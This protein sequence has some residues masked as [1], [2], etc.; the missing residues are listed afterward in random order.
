MIS[1]SRQLTD[2][3]HAD[4]LNA[5]PHLHDRLLL[6]ELLDAHGIEP[7]A[8]N[9]E[10]GAADRP[11]RDAALRAD[12]GPPG[13]ALRR[14]VESGLRMEALLGR[15]VG[16]VLG[17]YHEIDRILVWCAGDARLART[18]VH[19]VAPSQVWVADSD[20]DACAWQATHLGVNALFAVADP[21][22]FAL[23]LDFSLVCAGSI[24]AGGA[25]AGFVR[26]IARLNRCVAKR[27]VLVFDAGAEGP[28]REPLV[29]QCV[30]DLFPWRPPDVVRLPGAQPGEPELF[31]V[32]GRGTSLRGLRVGVASPDE[33]D[34]MHVDARTG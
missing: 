15:I 8:F 2:S 33:F 29:R 23:P 13:R 30:A 7:G 11:F 10:L 32:A 1:P 12:G 31:V 24:P 27:G 26:W 34:A 22:R 19:R 5:V 28:R 18:L 17:G 9:T 4:T 25:D 20:P 21:E 6:D 16:Q 14:Y 3:T